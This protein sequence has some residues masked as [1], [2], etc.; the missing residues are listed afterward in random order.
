MVDN[1]ELVLLAI[2]EAVDHGH[3]MEMDPA[4]I[5]SRVLMRGSE[6]PADVGGQQLGDLSISQALGIA[7]AQFMKSIS[8]RDGM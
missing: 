3:V 5:V 1:F 2:D 6:S 8:Q 4:S 7:S